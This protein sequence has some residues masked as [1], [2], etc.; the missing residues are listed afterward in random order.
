M[1]LITRW[2]KGCKKDPFHQIRILGP[3]VMGV[4]PAVGRFEIRSAFSVA[5]GMDGSSPS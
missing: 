5:N 4:D 2:Q 3:G 1:A